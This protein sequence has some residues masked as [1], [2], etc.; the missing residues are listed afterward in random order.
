MKTN[1]NEYINDSIHGLILL[2]ELEKRIISSIGFNRL[3][4]VYQNSTVYL[5]FPSN[6]T[7]RFEH[8][9]G[10]MKLCSDMFYYS[11][12]NSSN[13][14]LQSFFNNFNKAFIKIGIDI[15]DCKSNF[16]K[17]EN[18]LIPNNLNIFDS[19]EIKIYI[20]LIQSVRI[21]ALLHDIG[22]TPFSHVIENALEY[23]YKE[24][25]KNSNYSDF[26]KTM[27][28]Y[29]KNRHL[30]EEIGDNITK[31]IFEELEK[32]YKNNKELLC[33]KNVVLEIFNDKNIFKCLHRIIDGSVDCDRLDYVTRDSIN[34]GID[35]GKIDYKR[36]INEMKI[37]KH[38]TN[39]YIF[40]FQKKSINSIEDFLKRRLELYK[41]IIYHH[42]VIK[43][44]L[45]LK[46][47]IIEL[48]NDYFNNKKSQ[49]NT[50]ILSISKLWGPLKNT[51]SINE[52]SQW[53]DSY[54]ITMLRNYLLLI[55]KD[56]NIYLKLFEIFMGNKYSFSLIKR[57]EHFE[58]LDNSL[59]LTLNNSK[60]LKKYNNK[61]HSN[62]D[63]EFLSLFKD[64]YNYNKEGFILNFILNKIASYPEEKDIFILN[65]KNEIVNIINNNNGCN[66]I[67]D[68]KILKTGIEKNTIFFYDNESKYNDMDSNIYNILEIESNYFPILYVYI[69]FKDTKNKKLFEKNRLCILKRIGSA[70]GKIIINDYKNYFN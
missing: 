31:K 47:V 39:F 37:L 6:R 25:E 62:K 61:S 42:R 55:N 46:N 57:R 45:I 22:H 21:A 30:H 5:T 69:F 51:S 8:S 11:V 2:S 9:I 28:P 50:D 36:I 64:L 29:F 56:N 63:D 15:E 26:I 66:T 12:L 68:F 38:K 10:T 34:S 48:I 65:I 53:N 7:K 40:C 33:I 35:S 70:I 13:K 58:I 52:I 1:K 54:V 17:F 14:I 18:S 44:D 60:T 32:E 20:L 49:N 24:N 23:T 27:K 59:K 41:N 19:K 3:H 67:V 16:Y 43:T 4:D